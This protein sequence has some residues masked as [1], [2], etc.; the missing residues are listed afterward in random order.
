MK[1]V[2]MTGFDPFDNEPINAAWEVVKTVPD[3]AKAAA[4]DDGFELEVRQIPTVFGESMQ[5]L[6]QA[7]EDVRPDVVIC[8]GQAGG[9]S[10]V[11]VERI[12]INLNDA[13]IPDNRGRLLRETPIS[14]EGPAA[15][16]ST[17]PVTSIVEAIQAAGIPAEASL[18]AGTY[19]CNHVLYG[20]QDIL[21]RDSWRERSTI[22][23]FIHVPFLPSQSA[24]HRNAPCLSADLVGQALLIA[25]RISVG[26][27]TGV[28]G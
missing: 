3:L 2:L 28:M 20:L 23:G 13:R 18:S 14:A 7:M 21:H 26:Q 16:F 25:T 17:L 15:W 27:P 19:V 4:T 12:G 10:A 5:V 6:E 11:S 8:V 24:R 1:K 22:G 9:R